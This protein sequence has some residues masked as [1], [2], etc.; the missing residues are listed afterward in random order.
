[1]LD[2]SLPPR[3]V[4]GRLLTKVGSGCAQG[5]GQDGSGGGHGGAPEDE[6]RVQVVV[7]VCISVL[8]RRQRVTH[9]TVLLEGYIA[10]R[11]ERQPNSNPRSKTHHP[12]TKYRNTLRA[13]EVKCLPEAPR[14]TPEMAWTAG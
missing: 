2:V 12:R 14:P 5:D 11:T 1:M 8:Y 7:D 13:Q 10:W 9:Y 3:G 4:D 6:E